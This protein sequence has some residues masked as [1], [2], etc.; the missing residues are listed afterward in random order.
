M[1][2]VKVTASEAQ[3]FS[4]GEQVSFDYYAY[5]TVQI[6]QQC[7]F[8]ENLLTTVYASGKGIPARTEDWMNI[9]F[10]ARCDYDNDARG[11]ET[12]GRLYNWYAVDNPQ[13][14]CP[15]GWHVPTDE[16]WADLEGYIASQGFRGNEGGALKGSP[17]AW[18]PTEDLATDSFGFSALPGGNRLNAG[19]F[20]SAGIVGNWWSSS[21]KRSS[22]W[23]RSLYSSD[24]KIRRYYLKRGWGLSVRCLQD[25]D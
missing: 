19:D 25:A 7:W 2:P 21:L 18:G 24:A 12:Y 10:G 15:M 11:V 13:G 16:E 17:E 4:C 9:Q 3:T 1:A 14:L 22:A 20:K 5:N 8:A 23:S 6:G